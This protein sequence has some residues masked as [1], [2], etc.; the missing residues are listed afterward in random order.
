MHVSRTFT[1]STPII[2]VFDYLSDFENTNEWDP[3]TIETRRS[4]GDGG[5]GTT[6][7]NRSQFMGRE[8]ELAYETI[9]YRRPE[10]FSAR[11]AN[12][13][14]TATDSMTFS[15]T[16]KGTQIEYRA[17]FEFRGI[18]RFLAPLV[19]GRKLEALAD[20]TVGQIRATLEG[21]RTS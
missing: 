15:E 19:V 8:V 21:R 1:V 16:G 12:K 9:G 2:E 14:A 13:T 7:S 5:L 4:A 6:Y 11:G 20:E 17:D 3:G 18:A 10:F